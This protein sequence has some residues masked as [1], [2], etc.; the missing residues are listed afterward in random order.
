MAGSPATLLVCHAH[1]RA[2][3]AAS[4]SVQAVSHGGGGLCKGPRQPAGHTGWLVGCG[5]SYLPAPG[6]PQGQTG[7]GWALACPRHRSPSS[8][9]A[10]GPGGS[11]HSTHCASLILRWKTAIRF[12]F[13]SSNSSTRTSSGKEVQTLKR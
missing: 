4:G 5:L 7:R 12:L 11:L 13:R 8:S 3:V 2:G 6:R 9:L 1:T 10:F